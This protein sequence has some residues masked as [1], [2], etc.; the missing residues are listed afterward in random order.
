MEVEGEAF[1]EE[2]QETQE[3]EEQ[4][5]AEE[6]P[7]EHD[8]ECEVRETEADAEGLEHRDLPMH[9]V[10]DS[11]IPV[12]HDLYEATPEKVEE[13]KKKTLA[14]HEV[15]RVKRKA[16]YEELKA[17]IEMLEP[18]VFDSG[19]LV[20]DSGSLDFGLHLQKTCYLGG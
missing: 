3:D 8:Q 4:E 2:L 20:F 1:K 17:K 14:T 18:M 6:E 13:D 10:T 5:E 19:S 15:Q 12:G 11:Q 16:E 9:E 7:M